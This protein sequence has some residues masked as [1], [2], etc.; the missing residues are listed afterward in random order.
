MKLL[1]KT[2]GLLVEPISASSVASL[3]NLLKR[4]YI[5]KSDVIVS[6]ATGSGIKH[7]NLADKLAEKPVQINVGEE[8]EALKKSNL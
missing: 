2:E 7:P 4:G 6:I 3:P 5:N 8:L 1:A